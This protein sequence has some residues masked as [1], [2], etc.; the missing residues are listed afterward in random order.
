M[1]TAL[2]IIT[3]AMVEIG[4]YAPGN[5]ISAAHQQV[6]LTRFQNQLDSWQSDFLSLNLQ[7]RLTFLLMSG[8]STF[9]IGPS[10]NLVT[11]RPSYIEGVNYIIPGTS[12]ATEVPMAPL[13][14]D[15]YLAI[16]QKALS[17]SLPQQY[18]YNQTATNGTMNIWPVVTQNVTLALYLEHGIDIPSA[19]NT[20]VV[21]PQSYAEAFMYQLA[22]RLCG[23]M[24]RPIP[25]ALPTMAREAYARMQRPNV[26]PGILGIDQ[27]LVSASDGAGAF[28]VLTG[29]FSGSSSG[30]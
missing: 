10:G 9:T 14:S 26:E 15:Q 22:L 3:D 16:S 5:T 12:P 1:A 29:T 13:N 2:A 25:P 17:N 8:T 24:S 6:G 18:Y 11:T 4:A 28:N 27:A 23:P 20:I 7:D 21:G 30:R 19:L